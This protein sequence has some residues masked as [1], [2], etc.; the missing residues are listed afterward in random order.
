[1]ETSY[2]LPFKLAIVPS[3]IWLI[4][5]SGRRWGPTVAGSL[6]AFPVV[7]GP[8]LLFVAVEQGVD[9]AA[10]AAIGS[11]AG[12]LALIGFSL[13]YAICAAS[14]VSWRRSTIFSIAIY[15]FIVALLRE[16][17][18]SLITASIVVIVVLTFIQRVFPKNRITKVD[19]A[20]F[21]FDVPLRMVLGGLMVYMLTT[22]ASR[23]GPAWSGIF[24]MFPVTGS[25]LMVFSHIYQGKEF[26]S[27]LIHGMF[28]G[29][30]SI[31]T[32]CIVLAYSLPAVGIVPSF[33]AS[34]IAAI[35]TQFV[36]YFFRGK[37][38]RNNQ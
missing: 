5:Y 3:L 11:I 22:V 16:F 30:C 15:A 31:T 32:F 28:L 17:D 10:S 1:M 12:V 24:A 14:N 34:F 33:T 23:I 13:T 7:V 9:F 19:N 25:I 37:S 35:I 29:W 27:N 2:F 36:G 20:A 38:P 18:F 21:K 4:S 8:S 6:S 26:A